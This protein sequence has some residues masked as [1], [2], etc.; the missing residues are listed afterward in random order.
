MAL[1]WS[2]NPFLGL[3]PQDG[4]IYAE[5][6]WTLVMDPDEWIAN[7]GILV[8]YYLRGALTLEQCKTLVAFTHD[9]SVRSAASMSS[10]GSVYKHLKNFRPEVR[11]FLLAPATIATLRSASPYDGRER[12]GSYTWCLDEMRKA[13]TGARRGRVPRLVK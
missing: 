9:K 4:P 3:N 1:G 8:T 2:L 12:P 7:R 6:I 5:P 10:L 11:E 13:L